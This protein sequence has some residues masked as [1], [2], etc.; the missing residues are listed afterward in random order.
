MKILL[1][2]PFILLA[3]GCG[4]LGQIDRSV[5]S[6]LDQVSTEISVAQSRMDKQLE[7]ID[8]I[9]DENRK[10]IREI[11]DSY[12][13]LA[14]EESD[15]WREQS[16]SWR[17]ETRIQSELWREEIKAQSELMRE[18]LQAEMAINREFIDSQRKQAT[19]DLNALVDK[20]PDIIQES[21]AGVIKSTGIPV[22]KDEDGNHII[23]W[24]GVIALAM[25]GGKTAYRRMKG[26][27]MVNGNL[28]AEV[29][30]E[31]DKVM[32]EAKTDKKSKA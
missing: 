26:L 23:D 31:V 19:D 11:S 24:L 5:E 30:A 17:E 9:L 4:T 13:R 6:R 16:D 20:V 28:R 12:E 14:R 18:T 25:T 10:E 2:L 3:A 21:T 29:Q 1:I 7:K 22:K 32:A 8:D 15:K 27:K